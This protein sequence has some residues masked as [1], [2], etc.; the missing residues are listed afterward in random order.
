M[1]SEADRKPYR[2]AEPVPDYETAKRLARSPDPTDRQRVVQASANHPELLYFLATDSHTEVRRQ[3]AENPATPRQADGLLARDADAMVRARVAFKLARLVPELPERDRGHMQRATLSILETLA[4]DQATE[5]RQVLSDALKDHPSVPPTIIQRLAHDVE[6]RVARPV[7]EHSPILTEED[8]LEIILA[9]PIHGALEAIARR[10]NLGTS[11]SDAIASSE[12][13]LAVAALLANPS[14]QIR[15][16]TLDRLIEAAPRYQRWHEPLVRRPRLPPRAALRLAEFVADSLVAVLQART[17]L[18]AKTLSALADTVRSR[19]REQASRPERPPTGVLAGMP[20]PNRG[21]AP[22]PTSS[23]AP[24]EAP[25]ETPS[26]AMDWARRL[27]K[28]NQLTESTLEM[29]LTENRRDH[30]VAGLALL[31]TLPVSV[32]EE[33]LRTRSARSVTALV[34]HAGLGMPFAWQVQVRLAQI[35]PDNTLKPNEGG[36]YPFTDEDLAWQMRFFLSA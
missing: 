14:A 24:V 11:I 25:D 16:E 35:P 19:M 13:E 9:G 17:D 30:V 34:W 21:M 7:L 23:T 10:A 18:P 32:V 29:A 8:L 12:D 28:T 27:A 33:I 3:I 20:T 2:T 22:M 36:G 26:P 1:E 5:V 4:H 31:G 6:I 15:E